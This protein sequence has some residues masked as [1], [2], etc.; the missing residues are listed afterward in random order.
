MRTRRLSGLLWRALEWPLGLTLWAVTRGLLATTHLRVDPLLARA[1]A[2]FVH[3]HAHLPV[4]LAVFGR[5]GRWAM[6]SGAPYMAPIARMSQLLGLQLA[7]GASGEGGRGALR[8]LEAALGRGASVELAVDGPAGPVFLA[9]PGCVDLALATGAPLVAVAYRASRFVITPGR[10]D[11]QVLPWP[12]STIEVLA[13]EVPRVD[14]EP[15]EALLA[16]VQATL[17]ALRAEAGNA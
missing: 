12:F 10:W 16:R 5:E 6:V 3:W 13:R 8:L 2:V 14:G 1:P 17:E 7:R 9:K 4:L 11:R 15:R